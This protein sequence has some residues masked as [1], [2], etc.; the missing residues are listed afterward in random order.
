MNVKEYI[1]SGVIE[2]YVLGI[3]TDAER[4][5]FEQ[6][7]AT[8]P[9]VVEARDA[10]ERSLELEL[11]RD[12]PPPPVFIREKVLLE[13]KP[14]VA[15]NNYTEEVEE[16]PVRRMNPWKWIAAASLLLLAGAGYWAYTTNEKY[17]DAVA[18]QSATERQLQES[19]AQLQVLQQD[20]ELLRKPG[21]RAVALTG[22]QDAPQAQTT[23][24]WDTTGV[25]KDV[26][27]LINN[28]P[29]PAGDKQYQLWA[30]LNNQPID[31][32][33]IE[34]DVQQKRLLV[35]MKN[36]QNAQAFAITLE[37]RGRANT[38]TPQGTMYAVGKL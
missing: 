17:E 8:Y 20:A 7:C 33:F 19:T 10:F 14:P 25:N 36:V 27:L 13:I 37:Q 23:I 9:E 16:A 22:T 1:R 2:S 21:M 34:M 28:L 38:A 29:Q 4:Q 31:L 32:G 5:E 15:E 35:K 12:A 30:L 24:F 18:R 11:M 6:M 3:A 26:Y